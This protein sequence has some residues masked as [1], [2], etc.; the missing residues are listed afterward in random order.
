MLLEVGCEP[1][2]SVSSPCRQESP[3]GAPLPASSAHRGQWPEP[4][5]AARP[6]TCRSHQ[7]DPR[8]RRRTTP[9]PPRS[10]TSTPPT[11]G[12]RPATNATDD[13]TRRSNG[14]S[15]SPRSTRSAHQLRSTLRRCATPPRT[16]PAPPRQPHRDPSSG[17]EASPSTTVDAARTTR[18][19]SPV[20]TGD[21]GHQLRITRQRQIHTHPH[22]V[23][24]PRHNGSRTSCIELPRRNAPI[25][26]RSAVA[27]D[28]HRRGLH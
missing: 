1:A 22:T 16:C 25:S 5:H 27:R 7:Q 12:S 11:R 28:G 23:A 21:R 8:G 14:E 10:S 19:R 17:D 15:R 4:Q 20:T 24:Q 9:R 26:H 6:A 13:V 2:S 3:T 18:E